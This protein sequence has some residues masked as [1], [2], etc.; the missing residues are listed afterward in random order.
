MNKVFAISDT[1]FC[2]RADFIWKAR[3]FSSVEEMDEK[4]IENWNKVVSPEDTVIHVGDVIFQAVTKTDIILPRLNGK[5]ILVMGNHDKGKNLLKYFD[6]FY[7]IKEYDN[8]VFSHIPIHPY[9]LNSRFLG[10]INIHGHIHKSVDNS[11]N[12]KFT[13]PTLNVNCE[14]LPDFAPININKIPEIWKNIYKPA[15]KL[16]LVRGIPGVGK[17]TYAKNKLTGFTFEADMYFIDK[18][19]KYNFDK[20]KLREAHEWC[21]QRTFGNLLKGYNVNVCNTFTTIKEMEPYIKF[22]NTF[23]F[24]LRV[25]KCTGKFQSIHNVPQETIDKMKERWQDYSGEEIV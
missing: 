3:G 10:K 16:T 1:H 11:Y 13:Y 2:H 20:D 6:D 21:Q 22:A 12:F 7:S 18:E 23:G 19:G 4:L 24:K 15:N 14:F 17:S 5:K 9:E 8:Y 25:I